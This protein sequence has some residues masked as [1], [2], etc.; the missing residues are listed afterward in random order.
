MT[1]VRDSTLNRSAAIKPIMSDANLACHV[2]FH[3]Y[4]RVVSGRTPA[5]PILRALAMT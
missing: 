2:T 1:I 5:L 3:W 4:V